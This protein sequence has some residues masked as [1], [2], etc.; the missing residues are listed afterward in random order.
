MASQIIAPN[1]SLEVTVPATHKVA[2]ATRGSASYALRANSDKVLDSANPVSDVVVTDGEEVSAAFASGAVVVVNNMGPFNV[3]VETG[4]API[5]KQFHRETGEQGDPVLVAVTGPISAADI[6]G[7]IVTSDGAAVTGTMPTGA[8]M[9]AASDWSVNESVD[10]SIIKPGADSFT[11]A[12]NTDHTI[13]GA[14]L[15]FTL[16]TGHWR[17]RKVSTGVFVTYRIG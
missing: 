17:T 15:V 16:L 4:T 10:W 11:L 8:E 12:G 7:G 2:I 5:C 1:G 3:Y 14:E 6:L 13:V 9:E